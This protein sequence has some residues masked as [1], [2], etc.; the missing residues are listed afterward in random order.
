MSTTEMKRKIRQAADLL[1]PEKLAKLTEYAGR[2]VK[3]SPQL[4][5]DDK[6]KIASMKRSIA[7]AER[8]F[9]QGKGV[10]WREIRRDV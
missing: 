5:A 4:S 8:D 7:K 3:G 2:L 6:R 10:N 9:A 1:P